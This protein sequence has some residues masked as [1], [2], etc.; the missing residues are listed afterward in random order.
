DPD[1]AVA[2][3]RPPVRKPTSWA[4]AYHPEAMHN[5]KIPDSVRPDG[6]AAATVFRPTGKLKYNKAFRKV[7]I[8]STPLPVHSNLLSTRLKGTHSFGSG[9]PPDFEMSGPDGEFRFDRGAKA[10][11]SLGFTRD[12][13][14][15]GLPAGTS[16]PEA[17]ELQSEFP[18]ATKRENSLNL[19]TSGLTP[20]EFI[21]RSLP[22]D[23]TTHHGVFLPAPGQATWTVPVPNDGVL[24]F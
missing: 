22:I 11:M 19:T 17:A 10:R 16:P 12:S 20:E 15:I 23:R 8:Y 5:I 2:V 3:E 24:A 18:T 4:L 6:Q 14:L 13:L 7:E 21:L 1:P 9:S